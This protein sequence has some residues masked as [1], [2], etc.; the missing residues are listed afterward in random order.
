MVEAPLDGKTIRVYG[1]DGK[2]IDARVVSARIQEPTAALLSLSGK[3][4]G[5]F[6]L[7]LAKEGTPVLVG[8]TAVDMTAAWVAFPP[9]SIILHSGPPKGR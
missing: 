3:P 8:P 2:E 1:V 5:P 9:D 6:Y 7:R 4:V